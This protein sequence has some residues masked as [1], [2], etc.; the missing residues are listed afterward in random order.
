MTTPSAHSL[1]PSSIHASSNSL[2]A[3]RPWNQLWPIS[4]TVTNSGTR[5]PGR[6]STLSA[7]VVTSVGYSMPPAA[8][9]SGGG[10]TTVMIDH[11]YGTN[12]FENVSIAPTPACRWRRANARCRGRYTTRTS[13]GVPAT[14]AVADITCM[15]GSI[16][17]AK[18]WT[19]S[20]W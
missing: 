6:I 12:S 16:I 15:C 13:T 14:S 2:E 7:P 19:S 4:W 9:A 3:S 17:H 8:I 18:S 1:T 10:S 11:G 20:A 5:T